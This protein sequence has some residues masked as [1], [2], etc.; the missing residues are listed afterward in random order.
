[1]LLLKIAS[2]LSSPS[3]FLGAG[4]LLLWP[5]PPEVEA[6]F[7]VGFVSVGFAADLSVLVSDRTRSSGA[8][9]GERDLA[10]L[11]AVFGVVSRAVLVERDVVPLLDVV[12]GSSWG[13]AGFLRRGFFADD[14]AASDGTGSP[15]AVGAAGPF[16]LR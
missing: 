8:A 3:F 7:P 12:E 13:G 10:L 11:F 4:A 15:S 2:G 14:S 1:M 5:L 6:F 16:F 9:L